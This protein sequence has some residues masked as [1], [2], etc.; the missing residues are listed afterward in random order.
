MV[1]QQPDPIR[2]LGLC[3]LINSPLVYALVIFLWP[4]HCLAFCAVSNR[5]CQLSV[6]LFCLFGLRHPRLCV[7]HCRLLWA[8]FLSLQLCVLASQNTWGTVVWC[9]ARGN[10]SV[11][12]LRENS[13]YAMTMTQDTSFLHYQPSVPYGILFIVLASY[14]CHVYQKTPWTLFTPM[15]PLYSQE[16]GWPTGSHLGVPSISIP[17][18]RHYTRGQMP[19]TY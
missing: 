3:V 15:S 16:Q 18:G 14:V 8:G 7:L 12:I 11:R 4:H 6:C 9:S 19:L 2:T 13:G 5:S 1:F 17:N 10:K